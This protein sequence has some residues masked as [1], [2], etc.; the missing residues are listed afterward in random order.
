MLQ[1]PLLR[2]KFDIL[3]LLISL[4]QDK[5]ATAD[6]V[7]IVEGRSMSSATPDLRIIHLMRHEE[8]R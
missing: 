2:L 4:W 6:R 8:V 1:P 5:R 3:V 7:V